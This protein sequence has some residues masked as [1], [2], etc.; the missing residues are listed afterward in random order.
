MDKKEG[1][2]KMTYSNGDVYDGEWK[3]DRRNGLGTLFFKNGSQYKG[4]WLDDM[5]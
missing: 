4:Y 2:G 1:K 5:P 3:Y